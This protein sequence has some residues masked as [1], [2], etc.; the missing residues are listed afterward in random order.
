VLQFKVEFIFVAELRITPEQLISI[1]P[2]A[3]QLKRV[4]F[5]ILP[6]D[7]TPVNY[8]AAILEFDRDRKHGDE[9]R[10]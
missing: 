9:G 2:H 7:T 8:A 6:D 10:E 1:Y 3:A 5:A 4:K